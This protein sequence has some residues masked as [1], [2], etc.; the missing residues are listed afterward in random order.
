MTRLRPFAVAVLAWVGWAGTGLAG[1]QDTAEPRD[2]TLS[3]MPEHKATVAMIQFTPGLTLVA[4]CM[5]GVYDLLIRGLPA[6]PGRDLTRELGFM[7]GEAGEARMT[8]WTVGEDRTTAFSR[9]PAPVARLLAQGGPLQI[10][11]PP[12]QDRRRIR[13][14]MAL[15]PS[16]TALGETLRACGRP[17]VDPRDDDAEGEGQDGL[18]TAIVWGRQPRASFPPPVRGRSPTHG[19]VV[20]SCRALADGSLRECEVESEHPRG[21]ELSDAALRSVDRARVRATDEAVAHGF[22]LEG[23]MVVFTMNFRLE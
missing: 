18:P 1:A 15:D 19:Y 17:L 13:Y 12:G 3:V 16:S 2:W 7:V 23:R 20:L 14:V 11:V 5:D 9:L 4:R 22:T 21:F 8:I 6:A 10:T